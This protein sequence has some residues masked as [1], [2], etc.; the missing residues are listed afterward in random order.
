[1]E[2]GREERKDLSS[3]SWGENQ[4]NTVWNSRKG[5]TPF[6]TNCDLAKYKSW[7]LTQ[8]VFLVFFISD[9]LMWMCWSHQFAS[10]KWRVEGKLGKI[11]AFDRRACGVGPSNTLVEKVL[12][13]KPAFSKFVLNWPQLWV[14]VCWRLQRGSSLVCLLVTEIETGWVKL[15]RETLRGIELKIKRYHSSPRY[16][17]LQLV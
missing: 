15:L 16:S 11:V 12:N 13:R 6:T 3:T 7:K 10:W 2:R 4:R 5:S 9:A 14:N 1:M 17:F 8:R